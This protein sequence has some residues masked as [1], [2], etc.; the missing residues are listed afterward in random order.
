MKIIP[1]GA[2]NI[3]FTKILQKFYASWFCELLYSESHSE[4]RPLTVH[5]KQHDN[6]P[7]GCKM[8][9]VYTQKFS[10]VVLWSNK[11]IE[12]QSVVRYS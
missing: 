11:I 2:T 12:Q 9:I 5:N 8:V 1:S 7:K 6:H 4:E 10:T 3:T